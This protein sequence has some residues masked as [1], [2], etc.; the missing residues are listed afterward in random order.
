M[1]P[2]GYYQSANNREGTLSVFLTAYILPSSYF[3]RIGALYVSRVTSNQ[4][5]IDIQICIYT[6]IDVY[7]PQTR[8]ID[9]IGY[10]DTIS[11]LTILYFLEKFAIKS[12]LETQIFKLYQ[13]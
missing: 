8:F 11:F 7:I 9:M 4:F 12:P 2:P 10:D 6:D 13:N 1:C 5:Y 3:C